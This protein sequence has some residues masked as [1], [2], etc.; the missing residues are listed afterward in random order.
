MDALN[1]PLTS[2][3][4]GLIYNPLGGLARKHRHVISTILAEL[5]KVS[6]WQ[7]STGEDFDSAV[8]A[9]IQTKIEWLIIIGGD[10]TIQGIFTRIFSRLP[11]NRWP[12]ISIIPGGTTNMTAFDLGIH[13]KPNQILERL[14]QHLN[15]MTNNLTLKTINKAVM[16]IEQTGQP[17]LYG[18]F[19]GLGL[20]ARGVKFSRS[21]IKQIGITGNIFT[22]IIVLRSLIGTFWGRPHPAWA[23]VHI[24]PP[25][26]TEANE[27]Q[28]YLLIMIST[29]DRILMGIR[30]Y[31]GQEKAPLHMTFIKQHCI[32][33]WLA[34]LRITLNQGQL[35]KKE[36][37]YLSYNTESLELLLDDEYIVDGELFYAASHQG[38]L[39]IS[40]KEKVK[41]LIL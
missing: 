11:S 12:F 19:F 39:R 36:H 20:I 40:A 2:L 33:F 28:P 23:P 16:R 22:S 7:I 27:P 37:G 13:E 18:M 29:L 35:L 32:R 38:P 6:E 31:W 14:R 8:N 9:L 30:P 34:I 41:F 3:R 5:P 1:L 17:A 24:M 15:Q 10:G 25:Q 26:T 4:I 21:R